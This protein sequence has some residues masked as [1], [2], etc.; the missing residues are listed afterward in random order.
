MKPRTKQFLIAGGA[1]LATVGV[2]AGVKAAQIGAMI[3]AGASYVPPPE[4]VTTATVEEV[5]WKPTFSA[6]GTT[7][8]VHGVTVASEVPGTVKDIA[9]ESGDEVKKGAILVRLD[10]SVE[11]AQLAAARAEATLAKL[12]L[13]RVQRLR[14]SNVSSQS[15]FDA[16]D[17][18]SKQADAAVQNIEAAIA[19]K[20]IRA[21]FAGRLGI[22]GVDLGQILA[23]GTPIVSL[24][25]YD[26]IYVEFW[27]PQQALRAVS[28]EQPVRIHSDTFGDKTW[29]G[30]VETV[31]AEVDATTR[32]VRIRAIVENGD[33]A[34]RPGMFVDVE[35]IRPETNNLVIIPETAVLHAPYGDSVYV[36]DQEKAEQTGK[37]Q[38]VAH[39]A[40]V[41]LGERRGDMVA[42]ESGLTKGQT[43]VSTGAFKLRNG[44]PVVINNEVTP[45]A[46]TH[47]NPEDQ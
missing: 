45:T 13:E 2:L 14:N 8:A 9:F 32:N 36:V 24:Q 20:T 3:N 40:F 35:V 4:P 16:A 43:V 39:Q 37:E 6:V 19:K 21:P 44:A 29:E 25:S 41:R 33:G 47:P 28:A 27:L 22:R 23:P 7:V 38:L 5:Q 11:T 12:T 26:P 18:K 42:I 34:L 17:A 15:E 31:D 30:S 1:V 10:A 46:S